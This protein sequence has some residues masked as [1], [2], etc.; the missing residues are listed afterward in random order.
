MRSLMSSNPF[1]PAKERLGAVFDDIRKKVIIEIF[2]ILNT[3]I[4]ILAK[5]EKKIKA[6]TAR[7][8]IFAN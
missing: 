7:K 3:I 2:A 6:C 4:I 5:K 8:N 1:E